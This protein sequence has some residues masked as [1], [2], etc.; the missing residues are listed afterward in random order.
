MARLMGF[1]L[2]RLPLWLLVQLCRLIGLVI[3]QLL[4]LVLLVLG[5]LSWRL[6]FRAGILLYGIFLVRLTIT[7]PPAPWLLYSQVHYPPES[8]LPSW[9]LALDT[10][11]LRS[12][13]YDP[14]QEI[15]FFAILGILLALIIIR[16]SR[17]LHTRLHY[18]MQNYRLHLAM[19]Q[20]PRLIAPRLVAKPPKPLR[21]VQPTKAN[22]TARTKKPTPKEK[23]FYVR[24]GLGAQAA[25]E[26]LDRIARR[27][28]PELQAFIG[29]VQEGEAEPKENLSSAML[30]K[31]QAATESREA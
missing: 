26:D 10:L 15:Q 31:Q 5:I 12:T 30:T 14:Q 29:I 21:Q 24:Y 6:V 16:L 22:P 20:P 17:P 23:P 8:I 19:L 27:L 2:W 1:L 11:L 18:A 25:N 9:R 7:P 4:G 3:S 13:L 28:S